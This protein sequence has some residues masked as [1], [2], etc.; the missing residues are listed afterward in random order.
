MRPQGVFTCLTQHVGSLIE[1]TPLFVRQWGIF[2]PKSLCA[3][4]L[5]WVSGTRPFQQFPQIP[6]WLYSRLQDLSGTPARLEQQRRSGGCYS[7]W[8]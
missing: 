3:V 7:R 4:N 8:L 5:K 2:L 6:W 1:T